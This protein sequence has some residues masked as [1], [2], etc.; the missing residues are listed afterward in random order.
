MRSHIPVARDQ[1]R[2]YVA[3][4]TIMKRT[5][6]REFKSA[7]DKSKHLN[8]PYTIW[9]DIR[10]RN[11]RA[12]R[13]TRQFESLTA[14]RR[15]LRPLN[16]EIRAAVLRRFNADWVTQ[17]R[18][19]CLAR[20]HPLIYRTRQKSTSETQLV[21]TVFRSV[22]T[23]GHKFTIANVTMSIAIGR[24]KLLNLVDVWQSERDFTDV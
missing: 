10:L 21:F 22:I 16:K 12:S 18:A 7:R 24:K 15:F 23:A 5:A 14:R 9:R 19:A 20:W 11:A 3:A 13:P 2:I 4:E 17:S 1:S 6:S 8:A